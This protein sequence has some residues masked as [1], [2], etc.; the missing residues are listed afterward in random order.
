M[1]EYEARDGTK[2]HIKEQRTLQDATNLYS[3]RLHGSIHPSP[4]HISCITFLAAKDG[5]SRSK[6]Y[7]GD[8]DENRDGTLPGKLLRGWQV[9]T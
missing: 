9:A 3:V 1:I 7:A 2:I 4:T 5:S 6:Q 8:E